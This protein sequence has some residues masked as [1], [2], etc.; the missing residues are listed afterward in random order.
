ML[1]IIEKDIDAII[2]NL[3]DVLDK[4][5]NKNILLAGGGGFLGYYFTIFFD[6]L[7]KKKQIQCNL[8][9]IDNFVSSSKN[10]A[11][12]NDLNEKITFENLDIC[13]ENN[14]NFDNKFDYIIHAAGIASPIYYRKKPIETLDVSISGSKNLLELAKNHNSKYIFF[15]SSEIYGDPF[16]EFV[17]INE[18]YRGN[19]STL[20]PRACYDEGKRVGET[21]CYI[22]QNYFDVH[23][24]IIRP[25]NIYGPGMKK[26]DYRV[27]ANFASNF[28]NNKPLN[29]YG[30]GNQTRTFCYISDGIEGFIRTIALG[31]PGEAYNIGNEKPEISMLDLAKLFFKIENKDENIHKIAYPSSYPADEPNRRCPNTFKAKDHLNFHAKISLEEGI[32]NYLYWCKSNF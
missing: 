26:D 9:L 19:V 11:F 12:K 18:E 22:Y 16:S 6:Q 13:K 31:Q 29:V 32:F 2:E 20:G 23:T 10:F 25:F 15:S 24:N 3:L 30:N 28:L 27:M 1:N 17:P 4:F 14:L 5:Q 7:A 8:T 21:M